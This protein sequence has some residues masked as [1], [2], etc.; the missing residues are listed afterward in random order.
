[1]TSFKSYFK[2]HLKANIRPLIYILATVLVLTFLI[3]VENQ[4]TSRY[5]FE[6]QQYY[7]DYKSTLNTPV[8]FL[9]ILTY[10]V[11]VMEFSFF[12]KRIN[13]DC[14]YS[15]PISRVA[16]GTVHYLTGLITLFGAFTAS[17]L[18][19]FALLLS[20]GPG[21][22]NFKPM[23]EHYLLALLLGFA[24]YS[25][26]VFIFNEAN[27]KGDGIWFMILY[28]FVL[29]LVMGAINRII[30]DY[31]IFSSG[32]SSIPVA[33]IISMTSN[34]KY[35]VEIDSAQRATFW[36]SP[37]Y[38]SWFIFWVVAGIASAVGFFLTF[39]KRRMERTEEI[40]DSFFGFR[41]LIPIY[42]FT[43]MITFRVSEMIIFWVII[44]LLALLGYTIYRRGF[45]YKK[46]D[47]I[48][49]ASLIIFL[50]IEI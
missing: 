8:I 36:S 17:Y 15:M 45:H 49:L 18:V 44:E 27:T 16:M 3:G 35:L 48:I 21:Y 19:N 26:M 47:F 28:T 32:T 33:L 25:L 12:K 6:L 39:G 46:S 30:G 2:S 14:A 37:E 22:F 5:D 7:Q 42:A 20:R 50:F 38:V 11:P 29:I 9:C 23:A 4:P 34:Y 1:M 41:T 40:S 31:N 43:G 13:L 10:V 24:I